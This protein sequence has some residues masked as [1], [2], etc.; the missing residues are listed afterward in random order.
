MLNPI[1]RALKL[2]GKLYKKVSSIANKGKVSDFS[3]S[4]MKYE[5]IKK[6]RLSLSRKRNNS[7]QF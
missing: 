6:I 3:E 4:K 1:Q 2:E 5:K 7:S